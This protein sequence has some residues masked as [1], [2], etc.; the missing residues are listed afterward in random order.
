VRGWDI[1]LVV[2]LPIIPKV[3]GSSLTTK[4]N[5]IEQEKIKGFR[6]SQ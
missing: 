2:Y 3:L 5:K 6:K 1:G 4:A